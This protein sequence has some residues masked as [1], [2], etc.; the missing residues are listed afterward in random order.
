MADFRVSVGETAPYHANPGPYS[1]N[2]M[3]TAP[4]VLARL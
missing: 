4:N 1:D 3:A 2:P